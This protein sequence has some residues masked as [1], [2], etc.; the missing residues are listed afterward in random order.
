MQ[1]NVTMQCNWYAFGKFIA[2]VRITEI[3]HD[4]EHD[5]KL[6]YID[7]HDLEK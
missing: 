5:H 3:A 6:L 1:C 4:N 7:K 2:R